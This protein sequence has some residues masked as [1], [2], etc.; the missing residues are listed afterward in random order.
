M[1]IRRLG[2]TVKIAEVFLDYKYKGSENKINYGIRVY[3][4]DG[5]KLKRY[6]EFEFRGVI[7]KKI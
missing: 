6:L 2:G 3:S 1:L 5:N 4:G 7:F